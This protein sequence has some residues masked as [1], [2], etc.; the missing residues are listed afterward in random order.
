[1]QIALV[2]GGTKGIGFEICKALGVRGYFVLVAGRSKTEDA[3]KLL[4]EQGVK[5]EG[6]LLDVTSDSNIQNAFDYISQKYGKLDVLVNN[7]GIGASSKKEA[8]IRDQ[9]ADV[10]D[11]NVASV[12]ILTDIFAR[13]ISKGGHII[14]VSSVRGSATRNSD[15]NFPPT[16]NLAYSASKAALNIISI[17]HAKKYPEL[18]INSVSPGHCATDFNGFHGKKKAS[19]GAFV[20]IELIEGRIEGSGGFWEFENEKVSRVPW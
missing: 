11:T 2:T 12:V 1:M 18:R 15:P 9:F 8:S 10:I 6:I 14:N 13:I 20:V 16:Q 19:E 7:A 17:E 4:T 5:A 3:V